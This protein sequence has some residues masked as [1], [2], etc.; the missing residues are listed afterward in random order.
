MWSGRMLIPPATMIPE[1]FQPKT[2]DFILLSLALAATLLGLVVAWGIHDVYRQALRDAESDMRAHL[3]A[4]AAALTLEIGAYRHDAWLLTTEKRPVFERILSAADPDEHLFSLAELT[5]TW[6]PKALAFTVAGADGRPLVSDFKG[7]IGEACLHDLKTSANQG[8]AIVPLHGL[9]SI[10]HIDVSAPII[11]ADGRKGV[12]LATFSLHTLSAL[13]NR[14]ADS[15]FTLEISAVQ[16]GM[17]REQGFQPVA[18]T[19]IQMHGQVRP[20]FLKEQQR[21]LYAR[22]AGYLGAFL[23]FA[24]AGL[25]L[26]WQARRRIHE[27]GQALRELNRALYTQS[28]NDPLTGLSNR[29]ALDRRLQTALAQAQRDQRPVTLALLDIDHFK[30]INDLLGHETGDACLRRLAEILK[31]SVQRPLDAAIRMGGE[32][33]L[34]CWYDTGLDDAHRLARDIQEKLRADALKHADGGD[35]TLSIGLRCTEGN[36]EQAIQV[37]LRDA[38]AALYRAK[39]GG[40]DRIVAA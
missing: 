3:Q 21:L 32:E 29:R 16:S 1:R 28:L 30:R 35:I 8:T 24:G 39:H 15:R 23:L 5:A 4:S 22:L 34:L 19:T 36:Q 2:A 7:S 25:W 13:A 26:A 10:P 11:G 9:S 17:G 14:H 38:D 12:F 40:R 20:A 18:G 31:A 37:L 27:D 33:F 6:F